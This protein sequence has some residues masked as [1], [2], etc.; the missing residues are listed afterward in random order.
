MCISLLQDATGT[1]N[2]R[3][4]LGLEGP[5]RGILTARSSDNGSSRALFEFDLGPDSVHVTCGQL[6]SVS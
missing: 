1:Q 5:L 4:K 3:D 6:L 2:R